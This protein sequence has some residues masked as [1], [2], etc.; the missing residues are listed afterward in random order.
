MH[1]AAKMH[2]RQG[3]PAGSQAKHAGGLLTD[4]R[5]PDDHGR[6]TTNGRPG[7]RPAPGRSRGVWSAALNH[8]EKSKLQLLHAQCHCCATSHRPRRASQ[9]G[10]AISLPL[11]PLCLLLKRTAAAMTQLPG[12]PCASSPPTTAVWRLHKQA[13]T[14][15]PTAIQKLAGLCQKQPGT[16]ALLPPK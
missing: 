2:G 7:L 6:H 4:Y 1:C 8:G 12:M 15:P 16:A 5:P 3:D 14:K 10:R 13:E 11:A 9:A